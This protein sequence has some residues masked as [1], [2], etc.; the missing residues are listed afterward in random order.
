MKSFIYYCSLAISLTVLIHLI[1]N[2]LQVDSDF[3]N[4]LVGI[5]VGYIACT[6][7]C[8]K[9]IQACNKLISEIKEIAPR[10]K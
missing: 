10:I 1:C 6:M 8:H 5:A 4:Y 2:W 3:K 9:Q 7:N